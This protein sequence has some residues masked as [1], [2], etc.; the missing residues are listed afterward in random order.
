MR[1]IAY[2]VGKTMLDWIDVAIFDVNCIVGLIADKVLP[3]T[4]LPNAALVTRGA[5]G[6]PLLLLRQ[7]FRET[8]LD[9]PPARREIGIVR[10]QLPDCMQVIGQHNKCVDRK[11]MFRLCGRYRVAQSLHV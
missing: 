6:T 9:Q 10:R 3:E 8:T 11:S 1:P 2:A 5:N 7:C 4:V